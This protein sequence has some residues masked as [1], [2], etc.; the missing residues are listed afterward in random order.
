MLLQTLF[1]S[2]IYLSSSAQHTQRHYLL[3]FIHTHTQRFTHKRNTSNTPRRTV[4]LL[5]MHILRIHRNT[6]IMKEYFKNLKYRKT[7]S[8]IELAAYPK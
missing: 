8:Y 5:F 7:Y 3:R 1:I 2:S 4:F 6:V